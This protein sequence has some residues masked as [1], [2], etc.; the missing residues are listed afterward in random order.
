MID[1]RVCAC[2]VLLL[3]SGAVFS[4]NDIYKQF[5]DQSALAQEPVVYARF[6]GHGIGV[7]YWQQNLGIGQ[8]I[9]A[10]AFG[11]AGQFLGMAGDAIVHDRPTALSQRDANE[12]AA[13]FDRA[14]AQQDLEQVLAEKLAGLSLFASPPAIRSL[15]PDARVPAGMFEEDPV[16]VVEL[17][18]SFILDYRALQV[19]GF[20]YVLSPAAE[21]ADPYAVNAGRLYLNR[22]D[23]VS[24]LLP[25][26]FT[27]TEEQIDAE[28]AAIKEK[29]KAQKMSPAVYE[30][31]KQEIKAA[32]HRPDL[33]EWR[34]PLL[35]QWAADGSAKLYE[36]IHLGAV[37][38]AE[39]I[40]QDIVDATP[41]V[42]KANKND[43]RVRT[44]ISRTREMIREV[45][46]P[47]AGAYTSQPTAVRSLLCHGVAYDENSSK[48]PEL[49]LCGVVR[50]GTYCTTGFVRTPTGCHKYQTK[51]G[52]KTKTRR[53]KAS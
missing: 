21:A 23:Y 17:F 35:E 13:F 38:I 25:A 22:F 46:G 2:G 11:P 36:A 48:A 52:K 9:G 42:P 30:A 18:A 20:A 49:N 31:R 45:A 28:V 27:K 8:A 10:I 26:P 19:T 24:D 15:D 33:E 51:K 40:A 7:Q 14:R 16:L 43:W 37:A 29:Y 41:V 44:S 5:L 50:P 32:K 39:L 4:Q 12:F 1:T 34:A 47:Y 53:K 3:F 6:D